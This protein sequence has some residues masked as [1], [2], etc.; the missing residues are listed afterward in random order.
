MLDRLT[1]ERLDAAT[2]GGLLLVAFSGGSDSTA[3]LLLLTQ[4]FG[5]S[6]LRV[7]IVDHAIRVGSADDAKR[8][9]DVAEGIGLR[10]DILTVAWRA[11][12]TRSQQ[13]AREARYRALCNAARQY[14]AH[15]IA[16]GH[17]ADDQAETVLM[18]AS[19]GSA[20]RGLA[21][22]A[23]F[24]PAPIWPEGRGIML[25][26]PLLGVR[27]AT[28]RSALDERGVGWID[29]PANENPSYERVRIRTRLA[30]LERAGFDVAALVRLAQR[31]R[32]IADRVEA[33]AAALIDRTAHFEADAITIDLRAWVG[34]ATVRQRALSVLIA[35]ASGEP[36]GPASDAVERL[37]KRM[38]AADFR[39]ATLGGAALAV[40]RARIVLS[41]DSGALSGRADGAQPAPPVALPAGEEVV[42]DGRLAI[43]AFAPGGAVY[44][45]GSQPRIEAANKAAVATQWLLAER[46]AHML[47]AITRASEQRNATKRD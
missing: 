14:G 13:S 35:A 41:R 7:A 22:I 18:R 6:R 26:R 28:L 43:T 34:D 45:D 21:G 44:A 23:P 38:R 15:A 9:S 10:A 31:M 47:G 8:A 20:W 19:A 4:R 29:D 37:E 27:R 25:G 30:E 24:A 40:R 16:L 46:V 33:A 1:I 42:W 32:A 39:G 5:V 17:T 2:Q 36:R 12:Q 3:L 11:G